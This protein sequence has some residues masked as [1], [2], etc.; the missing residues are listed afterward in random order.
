MSLAD[1]VGTICVKLAGRDAGRK[2]VIVS[3][4][5]KNH[6]MVTGPPSLTGL[7]RRKVNISHLYLTTRK[8]AIE[9]GSSD[10]DVLRALEEN[11]LRE[12]MVK[13]FEG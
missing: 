2:G 9:P 4:V 6:V 7:R 3:V 8:I 1:Y 11:G 12:F 13:R 5:D 10:E